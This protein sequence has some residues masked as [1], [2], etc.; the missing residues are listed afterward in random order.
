MDQ[1]LGAVVTKYHKRGGLNKRNVL[2]PFWRQEVQGQSVS[3]VGSLTCRSI[4]PIS[5]FI[6]ISDV[7]FYKGTSHTGLVATLMSSVKLDY[8]GSANTLSPNKATL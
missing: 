8:I 2:F 7:T 6:S 1:V 5:A 3:R 4:T